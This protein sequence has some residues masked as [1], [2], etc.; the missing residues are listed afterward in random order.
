M[1]LDS[2]PVHTRLRGGQVCHVYNE[3]AFR[4]FLA[5]ERARAQRSQRLLFLAVAAIRQGPG[6]SA[7][8]SDSTA[9][10]VFRGL[11]ASVREVDFVGWYREGHVAAAAL[12]QGTKRIDGR[13]AALIG[14][15]MVAELKKRLSA[16][17]SRNLRV[18]VVRL[19]GRSMT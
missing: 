14:D 13:A 18:R 8:L 7:K 10:A 5:V 3:A 9:V 6:R 2:I 4:H 15:R 1:T 19:G 11:S 12:T 17:D 16:S